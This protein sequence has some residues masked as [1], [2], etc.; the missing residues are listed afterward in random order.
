M[1]MT[2]TMTVSSEDKLP[3]LRNPLH[4]AFA[5]IFMAFWAYT[6][7][8]TT[9]LLNWVLENS[10]TLSLVIILAAFYNI[11]RFSDTSYTLI[12]LFMMLHVYGS[13]YQYADNPFGEWMKGQFGFSRNHYDRIVHFSFGLFLTFPLYEIASRGFK[14]N[15]FI[16]CLLVLSLILSLSALYELVEWVVAD[17][18]YEGDEQGMNYLGMQGDI[19]DAQ[20]DMALAFLGGIIAIGLA[21]LLRKRQQGQA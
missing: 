5:A 7:L 12:F 2:L 19:W 21:L 3:F 15:V 14:L 17:L 9:D 8:T 6:G 16:S 11:F 13:Q 10:L 18:V 4:I 20:K 1:H